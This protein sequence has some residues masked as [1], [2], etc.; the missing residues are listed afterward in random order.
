MSEPVDITKHLGLVRIMCRRYKS[1]TR[2]GKITMDDLFQEGVL[3]L[4]R[5]AET[6]E[7]ERGLRFS[8]FAMWWVRHHVGRAV[9]NDGRTIHVPV[10]M[11]DRCRQQDEEVPANT[12]SLDVVANRKDTRRQE[13]L[14][15]T[16]P[17]ATESPADA[18]LKEEVRALLDKARGA[19]P[20]RE[21]RILHM[22]FYQDKTYQA[23]GEVY[24]VSRERIRQLVVEGLQLMRRELAKSAPGLR[25]GVV[26]E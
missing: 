11:Q 1:S 26:F 10:Y 19:L 20:A 2:T 22:R 25:A 12:R 23:I 24:G 3:G 13:T 14:G 9:M 8:T 4:M 15:D 18:L 21:A 16:M 5:A 17:S 6:F 7:P